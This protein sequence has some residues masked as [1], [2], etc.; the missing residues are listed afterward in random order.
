MQSARPKSIGGALARDPSTLT[1]QEKKVALHLAR[2]AKDVLGGAQLVKHGAAFSFEQSMPASTP[3]LVHAVYVDPL[4][5]SMMIEAGVDFLEDTEATTGYTA[6][7]AACAVGNADLVDALISNG[8]NTLAT[9]SHGRG[10]LALAVRAGDEASVLRLLDASVSIDAQDND[11][12]TPLMEAAQGMNPTL[13]ETLVR[14]GADASVQ[15]FTGTS[16]VAFAALGDAARYA[17]KSPPPGCFGFFSFA[18]SKRQS[19]SSPAPDATALGT[20]NFHESYC[21]ES[22]A[23][24]LER[25]ERCIDLLVEAG[26]EQ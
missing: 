25:R 23:A 8:A 19:L 7:L 26:A 2:A 11:G 10:A 13:V 1:E 4:A 6:L 17:Q 15:T 21:D 16:A 5:A 3:R 24:T 18:S 14:A 12:V 20:G 22:E 9:D